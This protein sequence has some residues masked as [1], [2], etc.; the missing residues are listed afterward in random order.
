MKR[1]W[2]FLLVF[3]SV[4]IGF[5]SCS[6]STDENW[7]DSNLA[8]IDK[9][10]AQPGI[11]QVGDSLNGFTGIYY[12]V[13]K[14][15]SGVKPVIGNTVKVYYA[16]WMYNDTT[17]YEL[18]SVLNLDESFDHNYDFQFRVGSSSIIDGWNYILQT[19]PVGSRWR[20]YIPYHLA[21][22][23]TSQKGIPAYSTLIFD[24][25]LKEI[26]SQN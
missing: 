14:S 9:I 7:R 1:I 3:S 15:G 20:V 16:G 2:F 22:G 21:Y 12:Q 17:N 11:H 24:I 26:V 13:L 10:A 8:F 23:S 25:S 6:N 18:N 5:S 4:A 19:M